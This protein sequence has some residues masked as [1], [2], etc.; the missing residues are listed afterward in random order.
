MEKKVNVYVYGMKLLNQTSDPN[1]WGIFFQRQGWETYFYAPVVKNKSFSWNMC[2]GVDKKSKTFFFSFW[3]VNTDPPNLGSAQKSETLSTLGLYCTVNKTLG[4]F[5]LVTIQEPFT[6]PF[7]NTTYFRRS[8]NF[9]IFDGWPK[10]GNFEIFC[11]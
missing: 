7:Q 10:W 5:L 11:F 9:S 2:I 4:H 8:D 1:K 3:G 6:R